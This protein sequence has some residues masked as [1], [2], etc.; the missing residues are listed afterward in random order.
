MDRQTEATRGPGVPHVV[1]KPLVP[2]NVMAY[3][4]SRA[5]CKLGFP[6]LDIALAAAAQGLVKVTAA[7]NAEG[8]THYEW[9][10]KHLDRLGVRVLEALYL[11]LQTAAGVGL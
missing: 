6:C 11:R 5:I 7:E 4:L 3:S 8:L 9:S 10:E 2:Y 1:L